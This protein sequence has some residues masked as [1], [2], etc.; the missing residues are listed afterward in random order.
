MKLSNLLLLI[1]LSAMLFS[2]QTGKDIPYMTNIDEI[3]IAAL[4]A[5]TT[6]AG[7]F[8]I[9]P[10]DLLLINVASSN[11]D[12]VKPFNKLQY[13]PTLGSN[14]GY[15]I[16]DMTTIYYLVDD[17]GNIDFPVLGKLHIV[18]MTKKSIEEYIASL[19][20]PRYLTEKPSVECRIQNFRVFCLGDFNAPGIIQASNGRLNLIEAIAMCHDLT[21]QGKR[22]NIM[23]IRTDANGQRT[24]KRINLNDASFFSSPDFNLQ[25][26]DIIYVQPSEIK[27]RSAWSAP[28]LLN[29]GLS[30]LGTAM[31]LTTFILVLSDRAK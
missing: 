20:Y 9:K 29:F 31:S 27:A 17:N 2:C 3:P 21:L 7:D 8:T 25:Q 10:G 1:A 24:V 14:I 28:P 11:S 13:V 22:D 23:L 6:Q 30:M 5:A 16:G 26:N 18:N 4:S 15:N 19:I 12:A